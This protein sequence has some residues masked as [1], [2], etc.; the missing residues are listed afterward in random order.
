MEEEVHRRVVVG[1]FGMVYWSRRFRRHMQRHTMSRITD[2][3]GFEVPEI[4]VDNETDGSGAD[5]GDDDVA[6]MRAT[7]DFADGRSSFREMFGLGGPEGMGH[8]RGSSVGSAGSG[9]ASPSRSPRLRPHRATGS[10]GAGVVDLS[11]TVPGAREGVHSR[12]GSAVEE[13]AVEA[14]NESAWGESLRRSF[15]IRRPEG[16]DGG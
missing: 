5:S 11:E 4:V 1:F 14:F 16:R 6:K 13:M 7:V 2:L 15:T 3:S 9:A 10:G 8:E 12:H